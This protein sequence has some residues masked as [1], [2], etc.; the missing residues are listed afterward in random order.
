MDVKYE[1]CLK[2]ISSNIENYTKPELFKLW[3]ADAVENVADLKDVTKT[4]KN[5]YKAVNVRL[6]KIEENDDYSLKEK[7]QMV[8]IFSR[9]V[10]KDFVKSLTDNGYKVKPNEKNVIIFVESNDKTFSRS[11][12]QRQNDLH[13]KGE[14]VLN[15][16]YW[17][18]KVVSGNG[19]RTTPTI[20]NSQNIPKASVSV[21]RS[22]VQ[23]SGRSSGKRAQASGSPTLSGPKSKRAKPV[24]PSSPSASSSPYRTPLSP[25]PV[26]CR[27]ADCQ[28]D[29][30]MHQHSATQT[31]TI[32]PRSMVDAATMTEETTIEEKLIDS[33]ELVECAWLIARQFHIRLEDLG[34]SAY[35][36]AVL[37]NRG[38]VA[39]Y[40]CDN[41]IS[42]SILFVKAAMVPANNDHSYYPYRKF[43]RDFYD[44]VVDRIDAKRDNLLQKSL[45]LIVREVETHGESTT[46]VSRE[47]IFSAMKMIL[48]SVI[49]TS[50]LLS[51][52]GHESGQN[53]LPATHLSTDS[54]TDAVMNQD[55]TIETVPAPI[56]F[57]LLPVPAGMVK[58]MRITDVVWEFASDCKIKAS[59]IDIVRHRNN[60][61][62]HE[63]LTALECNDFIMNAIETIRRHREPVTTSN[64]NANFLPLGKVFR[65]FTESFIKPLNEI[66]GNVL[67]DSSDYMK[68]QI[69]KVGDAIHTNVV[70]R[71]EIR[72]VLVWILESVVPKEFQEPVDLHP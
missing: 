38:K 55:D 5:F 44:C 3:V 22:Q 64:S 35:R 47:R 39:A 20:R 60:L 58:I 65:D 57:C 70:P 59:E 40:K 49:D 17:S 28:T 31:I 18:M 9:A 72:S 27:S 2:Y 26:T 10:S 23:R 50:R 19:Q 46:V 69:S 42:T 56:P 16:R 11:S 68:E 53:L 61:S 30:V 41:L 1:Q 45:E 15:R 13:F 62:G 43:L 71:K 29:S 14:P 48:D 66:H 36:D 37:K 51:A 25:P 63:L 67:G 6:R 33:R 7:L 54:K 34:W 52:H 8:F 24:T 4:S 32:P 12:A 21:Q